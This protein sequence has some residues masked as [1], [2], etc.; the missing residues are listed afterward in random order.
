VT[1]AEGCGVTPGGEPPRWVTAIKD[2]NTGR[3]ACYLV[4]AG[5]F[6]FLLY[7]TRFKWGS[8]YVDTFMELWIP[9]QLIS[10]QYSSR[11]AG[12]NLYSD[13]FFNGGFLPPY[14]M[15]FMYRIFGVGIYTAAA[16]GAATLAAATVLLYRLA[17]FFTGIYISTFLV[18]DFL[19]VH[20]FGAYH[21]SQI[22]NFILPYNFNTTLF[23]VFSM[24]ALVFFIAAAESGKDRLAYPAGAA[25]TMAFL[26]RPEMTAP[27]WGVLAAL[28]GVLAYRKKRY[29]PLA[30]MVLS[31]MIA[32]AAYVW[33][34]SRTGAV[35]GFN[36]SVIGSIAMSLSGKFN[37]RESMLTGFGDFGPNVWFAVKSLAFQAA[38]AALIYSTVRLI[39]LTGAR[40]YRVLQ[41][42]FAIPVA[43]AAGVLSVWELGEFNLYRLMPLALFWMTGHYLYRVLKGDCSREDFS[44]LTLHGVTLAMTARIILNVSVTYYGFCLLAPV[45]VCYFLFFLEYLPALMRRFTAPPGN[46]GR[47]ALR[48]YAAAFCVFFAVMALPLVS[49]SYGMYGKKSVVM[50][51]PRGR[52]I[53]YNDEISHLF[54]GVLEYVN[55]FTPE[56]AGVVVIPQGL[57]VNYLTG[58]K[59]PLKYFD[60]NPL[61]VAL[62][63]EDE[64]IEELKNA[65]VECI[66]HLKSIDADGFGVKGFG[67]GYGRKINEWI[68]ANY[69]PALT[70]KN[71]LIIYRLKDG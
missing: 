12:K 23:M 5:S 37:G 40:L 60:L 9:E 3:Y 63:G 47:A 26:S 28:G 35:E 51:T 49:L 42:V 15:A 52:I 4:M 53:T 8:L 19:F 13:L 16:L 21:Y 43:A 10:T 32:A 62:I 57:G 39:E 67:V 64:Y 70:Y 24:A 27:V 11:L 45:L 18:L 50:D 41:Y 46:A 54:W 17:R 14:L 61:N 69:R 55:K 65:R 38:A 30:A 25:L 48:A 66:I 20:A 1:E 36:R 33:F 22:F 29:A 7:F 6:F 58:R 44:R 59:N 68:K 2:K 71:Y 56:D 31:I 34:L